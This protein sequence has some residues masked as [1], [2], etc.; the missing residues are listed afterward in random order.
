MR[1]A[2]IDA[3]R[4]GRW[5]PAMDRADEDWPCTDFRRPCRDAILVAGLVV[6]PTGVS[7]SP[8]LTPSRRRDYQPGC[9]RTQQLSWTE[10]LARTWRY[11]P[12]K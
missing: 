9:L 1:H 12:V 2:F 6:A 8:S 10:P 11:A 4:L 3:S 5:K 7:S